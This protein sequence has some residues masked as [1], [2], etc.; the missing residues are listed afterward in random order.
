MTR[1]QRWFCF[2]LGCWLGFLCFFSFVGGG[3]SFEIVVCCLSG[4]KS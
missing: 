3:G 4:P 1:S 2:A